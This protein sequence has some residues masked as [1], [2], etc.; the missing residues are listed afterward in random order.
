M[1]VS[2]S[3][4]SR[5]SGVPGVVGLGREVVVVVLLL[6]VLVGV[7]CGCEVVGLVGVTVVFLVIGEG[8]GDKGTSTCSAGAGLAGLNGLIGVVV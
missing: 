2:A 3:S 7:V 1:C 4:S 6:V 5:V 8:C